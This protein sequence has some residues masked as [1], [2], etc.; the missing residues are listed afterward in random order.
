MGRQPTHSSP[1]L[2][3]YYV[4]EEKARCEAEVRSDPSKIEP[5]AHSE[6]GSK[7]LQLRGTLLAFL[8][9]S[10]LATFGWILGGRHP[11]TEKI[12]IVEKV[13]IIMSGTGGCIADQEITRSKP[14]IAS[15]H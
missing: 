7:A 1:G 9:G 3:L 5:Y 10:L 13:Y 11:P 8:C 12:I 15:R 14:T 2:Y 6:R 4:P